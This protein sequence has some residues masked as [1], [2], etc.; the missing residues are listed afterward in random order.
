MYTFDENWNSVQEFHVEQELIYA[1][2][3]GYGKN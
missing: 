2:E 3:Y 1:D